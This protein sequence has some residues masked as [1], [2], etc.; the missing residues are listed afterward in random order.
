MFRKRQN[1]TLA[2]PKRSTPKTTTIF[3]KAIIRLEGPKML[4]LLS[5]DS[6]QQLNDCIS[7]KLP[8][9]TLPSPIDSISSNSPSNN[10]GHMGQSYYVFSLLRD[11]THHLEKTVSTGDNKYYEET[12]ELE[13]WQSEISPEYRR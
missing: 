4:I 12:T 1:F 13:K 8:I 10:T 2:I 5:T 3:T 11:V 7:T 9:T 6:T